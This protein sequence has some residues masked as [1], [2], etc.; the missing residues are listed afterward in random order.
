MLIGILSLSVVLQISG[1][2]LALRLIKITEEYQVWGLIATALLLLGVRQSMLIFDVLS[3]DLSPLPNMLVEVISLLVSILLMSWMVLVAP[4]F[5]RIHAS[6]DAHRNSEIRFRDYA[7]IASDWFWEMGP[8][9]KFSFLS[10]RFF[11][12]YGF[13][14]SDRIG[15]TRVQSSDPADFKEN[16]KK[17]S[18]HMADLSAK[19]PFKNFEYASRAENGELR[20]IRSSG[21][22]MFDKAGVFCGYRGTGTDITV[23]K[24]AEEALRENA[25]RLQETVQMAKLGSWVWD[26]VTDR[27]VYCSEENAELHGVPVDEYIARASTLDGELSFVHE[28]DRERF[29]SACRE[30]RN[31]KR[32]DMEYRII[33][34]RGKVRFVREIAKPVFGGNGSVTREHGIIQDITYLRTTENAL[35]QSEQWVRGIVE[36]S[37]AAIYLKDTEGRYLMVNKT[38]TKWYGWTEEEAKGKTFKDLFPDEVTPEHRTRDDEVLTTGSVVD[39]ETVS[40]FVDG[41][42]RPTWVIKF[43]LFKTDGE[44]AAICGM[45]R[46]ISELKRREEEVIKAKEKAEQANKAKSDFLANM[47][48]EL[49][50]P[51]N[52]IIGFSDVISRQYL[53]PVGEPNYVEY[54]SDIHESGKY[55][56]ALIDDILDL[57]AIESRKKVLNSEALDVHDLVKSCLDMVKGVA[58]QNDVELVTKMSNVQHPLHADRRALT[59]ILLNLLS[60]AIKFTSSGGMVTLDIT[61][62]TSQRIMKV[63]DTGRGIPVDKIGTITDAFV[64][65]ETDPYKAAEGAG[66]GLAIVKSLVEFHEGKLDIES[67]VGTG[68]TVTVTLPGQIS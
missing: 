18:A 34:P 32:F 19:R 61:V 25:A 45:N 43:P 60:N 52:A 39:W 63:S 31:G 46:D 1:A 16:A 2:V 59:Q 48:H 11:D 66:L 4:V 10:N 13:Q 54:A 6:Q 21:T 5:T 9:L 64:R 12:I 22:P 38:F 44:I 65:G 20:Y 55:L 36:N 33:T 37:P 30:L 3:G 23:E 14:P 8:D 24:R 17:W 29:R 26:P 40:R 62:T 47:S 58:D 56:M 53:G 68:T 49:R 67:T 50:T 41:S 27:C 7:N 42:T 57:S 28:D 35:R 15:T 51:M